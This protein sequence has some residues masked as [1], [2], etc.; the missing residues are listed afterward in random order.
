VSP[1]AAGTAYV[2]LDYHEVENNRPY[3]FKTHDFGKSWTAIAGGLP[4]DDPAHV[5][6]ENPNR[7]G[8]LV[9]GTDAGLFYSY[10]EGA[11][12]SPMKGSFP[13]A[14]VYDLKFHG[15]THDLIVATH[16]RGLFVLDDITPLEETSP[17]V[18]A[19]AFHLYS[20]RP[21]VN[22][23]LWPGEKHGFST[24]GEFSAP[25][26]PQG[27]VISY[28][29][30]AAIEPEHEHDGADARHAAKGGQAQPPKEHAGA[31]APGAG[32]AR[33]EA[34]G[35]EEAEQAPEGGEKRGPVKIV[36]TD[37]SGAVVR[38]LYGPG[39]Q[40]INRVAWN[41]R[42]DEAVRLNAARPPEEDNPFFTPGGPTALPGSYKA[43]VTA[44]GKSATTEVA[45]EADPRVPFDVAAAR[46]Q[47]Q[48]AL[49][50]RSWM[51][52]M[53]ESLNRIDDLKAQL[54]AMLRLLGPEAER[55]GVDRAQYEPVVAQARA[56]REKLSAVEEKVLNVAAVKDPQGG[57]HNLARAHDRLQRVGR[58]VSMPYGQ[59]PT[60][61]MME[62]VAAAKKELDAFLAEFNELVRA[63]VPAFNTLAQ[64]KG[65][66]ALF[67]GNPIELKAAAAAPG[68]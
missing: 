28:H 48:Q 52:A 20:S 58:A 56:L 19:E 22:W 65:A 37:G 14:P 32:A 7:R 64:E 45:F 24:L 11:H 53:N 15:A 16:G 41:M 4:A 54:A 8:M 29:L 23:R 50:L 9:L 35:A 5:V 36:V 13:T 49:E 34:P 47:M 40:G 10:D 43:T 12:W 46:A 21:G 59:A 63:D 68:H 33:A 6:R 44:A 66:G 57:L 3:V 62:D 17:E 67:A 27:V 25:N 60:P 30:A 51:N 42:Y 38:T 2:A 61:L 31:P 1:F 18:L 55:T 39:K 26:P